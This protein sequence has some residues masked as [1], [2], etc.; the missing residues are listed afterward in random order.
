MLYCTYAP[1]Y[2][3]GIKLT[4]EETQRFVDASASGK[5]NI[6]LEQ[7]TSAEKAEEYLSLCGVITV[8]TG[9]VDDAVANKLDA[10]CTGDCKVIKQ[11]AINDFNATAAAIDKLYDDNIN[12][13]SED[14]V[15]LT[16]SSAA[17]TSISK[18][19]QL[20]REEMH[21]PDVLTKRL[22]KQIE[23]AKKA[24]LLDRR[25]AN[26]LKKNV[27]SSLEIDPSAPQNSIESVIANVNKAIR[28]SQG[29]QKKELAGIE[30]KQKQALEYK[31]TAIREIRSMTKTDA[32]SKGAN[33]VGG[34]LTAV[35]KFQSGNEIQVVSGCLDIANSIAQFLPPPASLVTETVSGIFNLFAG[36]P[37]DPSNQ[38]VIDEVKNAINK[39]FAHQRNFLEKKFAEHMNLIRVE[40]AK[41][42]NVISKQFSQ[43][44][45]NIA[46]GFAAQR[47]FISQKFTE[48]HLRK[49]KNEALAQLEAIEEKKLFIDKYKNGDIKEVALAQSIDRQ[50]AALSNTRYSSLSKTTF[51][52]I[53]PAI[54]DEKYPVSKTVTRKYCATLLYTYLMVEQD[55][56]FVL[57]ELT[58][59]LARTSLRRLED[60]FL[61]V[62]DHRKSE[63]TKFVKNIVLE[64]KVGCSLFNPQSGTPV[65][66]DKQITE[67]T[68]YI[69]YLNE[70]TFTGS[71]DAFK[72]RTD[73][74]SKYLK[75]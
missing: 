53:C 52:D 60:G 20:F 1:W 4:T 27:A 48:D 24:G 35:T 70:E 15:M 66:T 23:D 41:L 56:N 61:D 46:E 33:A 71:I 9:V 72:K 51:E 69:K 38:Q 36:G 49:V 59:V 16:K 62:L 75:T 32:L 50:I 10:I 44:G 34:V 54:L 8:C 55:R 29:I 67:I 73:C 18:T 37:P 3:S 13:T 40:F 26:E 25:V 12:K 65:L 42:E 43:L 63:V 28:Q 6:I 14:I 57:F 64:K 21:D 22:H 5:Q 74:P 30:K 2:F 7:S 39:G 11:K 31:D 45:E 19:F 17:L 47:N 68:T 58:Q